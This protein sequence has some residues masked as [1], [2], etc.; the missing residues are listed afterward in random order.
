MKV[1]AVYPN[2]ILD[3]LMRASLASIYEHVDRIMIIERGQHPGGVPAREWQRDWDYA[4]KIDYVRAP[5]A[6]RFDSCLCPDAEYPIRGWLDASGL[7]DSIV[8]FQANNEI[9]DKE[10]LERALFHAGKA[11]E[12]TKFW[13]VT[14]V[15]HSYACPLESFR[16]PKPAV[17]FFR[18]PTLFQHDE[19]PVVPVPDETHVHRFNC[20]V[21]P[22]R[23]VDRLRQWFDALPEAIMRDGAYL[24]EW[25]PPG[26]ISRE[27]EKA[28]FG[29]CLGKN[30]CVDLGTLRGRSAAVMALAAQ[31]VITVDL[32]EKIQGEDA[33]SDPGVKYCGIWE[34]YRHRYAAVRHWL[35]RYD[36]IEVIQGKTAEVANRRERDVDVVFF[37]ADHTKSGVAADFWAWRPRVI[38][39]GL[40]VFHDA[41]AIHPQVRAFTDTVAIQHPEI[42]FHPPAGSLRVFE[43]K[44]K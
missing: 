16:Y 15:G 13:G 35:S 5:Y 42:V 1:V 10:E 23:V 32:F 31:H 44:P 20:P 39:G 3:S 8:L 7:C 26:Q 37:D 30:L 28:L 34:E 36:N 22:R 14:A 38:P 18:A 9:W 43:N 2:G 21:P 24:S 25:L 11:P 17:M 6:E 33:E 29:L 19:H 41:N 27:E 4:R 40:F 12:E